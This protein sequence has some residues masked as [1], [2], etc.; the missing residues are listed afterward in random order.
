[1]EVIDKMG[2][3]VKV[4][5]KDVYPVPESIKKGAYVSGREMY[6]KMYKRSIEDPEGFW[7]EVAEENR[8]A[9]EVGQGGGVQL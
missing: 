9:Q 6:D 1:V 5:L 2:E 3:E 7:G 8:L 4:Q